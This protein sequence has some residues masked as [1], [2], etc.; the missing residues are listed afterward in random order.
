MGH[1]V[2]SQ[3]QV[4]EQIMRELTD[5]KRSLKAKDREHFD[6]LLN[7]AR[8]HYGSVSYTSSYHTWAILLLAMLLEQQKQLAR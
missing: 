1:T 4:S 5:F 3:R 8:K 7:A 6:S 2:T